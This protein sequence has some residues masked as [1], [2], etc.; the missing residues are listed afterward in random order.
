MEVGYRNP[1]R[2]V[3][4]LANNLNTD[5]EIEVGRWHDLAITMDLALPGSIW[6]MTRIL[7]PEGEFRHLLRKV[8]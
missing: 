6:M 5:F 8:P 4:E 1:Y 3:R 2:Y 7:P